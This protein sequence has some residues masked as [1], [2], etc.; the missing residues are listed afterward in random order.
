MYV[1]KWIILYLPPNLKYY[2]STYSL[3]NRIDT[4]F[5]QKWWYIMYLSYVSISVLFPKTTDFDYGR[6]S[7]KIKLGGSKYIDRPE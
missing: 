5:F 6:S 4:H 1:C 7:A 3:Q 2:F